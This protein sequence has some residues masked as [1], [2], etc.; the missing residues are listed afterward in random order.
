MSTE[1]AAEKE[2]LAGIIKPGTT[3]IIDFEFEDGEKTRRVVTIP[4]RQG[5]NNATGSEGNSDSGL[6]K[7]LF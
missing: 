3:L 4:E 2:N 5:K 7:T 6:R 1:N